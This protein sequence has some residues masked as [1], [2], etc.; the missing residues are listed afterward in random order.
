MRKSLL[1]AAI[2]AL[3]AGFS[4]NAQEAKLMDKV[5]GS[6]VQAIPSDSINIMACTA[7]TMVSPNDA[8]E[9]EFPYLAGTQQKNGEDCSPYWKMLC[10]TKNGT[11][12]DFVVESAEAS[13]YIIDVKTGRKNPEIADPKVKLTLYADATATDAIWDSEFVV[14]CNAEWN[15]KY[16]VNSVPV[17]T[18]I[19]AGK[20]LFRVEAIQGGLEDETNLSKT[21]VNI[22]GIGFKAV[23][24]APVTYYIY[25]SVVEL[26][27]EDLEENDGAGILTLTPASDTIIGGNE[28]KLS[29][30]AESGYKFAYFEIN[31]EIVETN[32]YTYV[33]KED[34]DIKAVFVEINVW[35]NVPGML[36]LE[37]QVGM[38]GFGGSESKPLIQVD[39]AV[40]FWNGE[41][42][43]VD[44]DR[45]K[46]T[47]LSEQIR[48]NGWLEY[49][50]RVASD[51][52]Y[53]VSAYVAKKTENY[54]NPASPCTTTWEFK[55]IADPDAD[56]IVLGPV[57]MISTE[58]WN[59]FRLQDLGE[60]DLKAGE[61]KLRITF[62]SGYGTDEASINQKKETCK[63]YQVVFG[64]RDAVDA[65]E[66]VEAAA[67]PVKAYNI[68]GMEVAPDTE[69][70]IIVNGKK[71]F[72]RK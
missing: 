7:Y 18:L 65:V 71:V 16:A 53:P 47:C 51:A 49:K 13:Y 69:G 11:Y 12:Y 1:L 2:V 40:K 32:P 67:A 70:L 27:G 5:Y 58:Q 48:G 62:V 25:S 15:A 72:N 4:A 43:E 66:A 9:Y 68:F 45:E 44:P 34:Q 42:Y 36:N 60:V 61:Y 8:G 64:D 14:P 35:N 3:G 50:L 55:S 30:T 46:I 28:L 39:Y 23:A 37:S 24:E 52:T 6:E 22:P 56:A 63:L 33:V 21:V 10:N 31:E 20:H 57:E 59:N 29:A 26:V 41:A 19:P 38:N 54:S 17:E